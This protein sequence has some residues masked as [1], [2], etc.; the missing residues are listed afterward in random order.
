M[1]NTENIAG[2]P[3]PPEPTAPPAPPTMSAFAR[4]IGIF[5]EPD[6]TFRDIARSPGFI[7]PL[8]LV[9]LCSMATATVLVNRLDMRD[10]AAKQIEKNPRT[11]SMPKEQKQAAIEMGAKIGTYATYA[12]PVFVILAVLIISGV[13][14]VMG[15]FVFGGT[16]TFKQIFAVTAHAQL[17]G[18]IIAILAI[19]ILFL[20]DPAD[21]D[22]Q[23]LVASN[24]GP[25]ISAETSKFL[26]AVAISI[27]LFSF[28]QIFLLGT[29]LAICGRL[30]RAKGIMAVVIPWLIYVLIKSG[31]ASLQG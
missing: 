12:S 30:S 25:L 19:V 14:L 15:N 2:T 3:Q 23:N 29:G 11:E 20:K 9:M 26:H 4:V 21:V 24:L 8:V 31:L 5:F 7:V 27:D 17:P 18:I 6:A 16:A 1:E 28:W 13:L 22:V 10:I